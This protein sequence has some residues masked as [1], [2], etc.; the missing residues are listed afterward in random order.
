[1]GVAERVSAALVGCGTALGRGL[2]E[3]EAWAAAA[4]PLPRAAL[5]ARREAAAVGGF[6]GLCSWDF[7]G[8]S[9]TR[10]LVGSARSGG[11]A[12]ERAGAGGPPGPACEAPRLT[13]AGG[14]ERAGRT[15]VPG[16][17]GWGMAVCGQP[18]AR[19]P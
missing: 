12:R 14:A 8:A 10:A 7:G 2:L 4:A 15:R 6:A 5:S 11:A 18:W 9:G 19:Q 3:L 13:G 1:M 17:C 16:R